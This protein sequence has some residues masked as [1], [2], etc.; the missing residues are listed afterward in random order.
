M[1]ISSADKI[2]KGDL[3]SVSMNMIGNII[4]QDRI[5]LIDLNNL[6]NKV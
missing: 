2:V 5:H 1:G 6:T 3:D 4:S